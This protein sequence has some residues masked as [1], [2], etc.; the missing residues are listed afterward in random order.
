MFRAG[1]K[2]CSGFELPG[3]WQQLI[4][5]MPAAA[6]CRM[7]QTV[8]SR[9]QHSI[10]GCFHWVSV[11]CGHHHTNH[12]T[13]ITLTRVLCVL[14]VLFPSHT[15]TRTC[16]LSPSSHLHAP[17]AVC[18]VLHSFPDIRNDYQRSEVALDFNAGFTAAAAG[19]AS[20]DHARKTRTCSNSGTGAPAESVC[21]RCQHIKAL[22]A[23]C[24]RQPG[25]GVPA[26]LSGVLETMAA[27]ET[28][29]RTAACISWCC[30]EWSVPCVST[31]YYHYH[32]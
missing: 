25:E 28:L 24:N 20:H 1:S 4:K 6:A 15:V 8:G 13:N 3:S 17:C 26:Q 14:C 7:D 19:L 27:Q 5:K 12:H 32:Y 29:G 22:A 9:A 16:V 18:L 2:P 10:S 23:A 30:L 11:G 31:S 21:L